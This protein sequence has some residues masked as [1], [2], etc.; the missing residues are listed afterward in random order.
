MIMQE[1]EAKR[2]QQVDVEEDH[3][4]NALTDLVGVEDAP[5]I[6]KRRQDGLFMMNE[7][8]EEDEYEYEYD[9][10]DVDKQE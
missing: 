10:E 2:A 1:E 7:V 8:K 3:Q 9:Q 5:K 4:F 6:D